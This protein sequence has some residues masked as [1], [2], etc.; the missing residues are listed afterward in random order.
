MRDLRFKHSKLMTEVITGH[1]Q[2][3]CV[4]LPNSYTEIPTPK[5]MVCGGETSG[6]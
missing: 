5:G 6:R 3:V 2:N 4:P 1:V